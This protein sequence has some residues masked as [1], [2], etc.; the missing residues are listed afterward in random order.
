MMG[1]PR[2]SDGSAASESAPVNKKLAVRVPYALCE[3]LLILNVL[4][5]M[6]HCICNI[7]KASIAR[8]FNAL[9]VVEHMVDGLSDAT[10]P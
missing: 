6:A 1:N 9:Q 7:L 4:F 3:I 5:K 2:T 8:K 10:R